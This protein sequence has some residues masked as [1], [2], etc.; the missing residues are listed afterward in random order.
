P[1]GI[2]R[3]NELPIVGV[4]VALPIRVIFKD[5][6]R[7]LPAIVPGE[8][9]DR[10]PPE[11]VKSEASALAVK[12]H[13][14]RSNSRVTVASATFAQPSCCLEQIPVPEWTR[15]GCLQLGHARNDLTQGQSIQPRSGGET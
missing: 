10:T 8:R 4:V 12:I 7:W 11:D 6:S 2:N 15:G 13:A 3:R 14:H 9:Q 1:I 5:R